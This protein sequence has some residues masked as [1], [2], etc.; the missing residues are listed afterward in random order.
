MAR[1][2]DKTRTYLQPQNLPHLKSEWVV[3]VGFK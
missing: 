1:N 2:G 3:K